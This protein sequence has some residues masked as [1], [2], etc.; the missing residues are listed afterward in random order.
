MNKETYKDEIEH[1][2]T[3]LAILQNVLSKSNICTLVHLI[4][5]KALEEHGVNVENKAYI[6]NQIKLAGSNERPTRL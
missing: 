3:Q 4:V 1:F 5:N 6:S 2:A